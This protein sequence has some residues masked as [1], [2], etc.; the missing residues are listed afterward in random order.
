VVGTT[1]RKYWYATKAVDLLV[2][3]R[4]ATL[5]QGSITYDRWLPRM[6]YPGVGLYLENKV[7]KKTR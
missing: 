7:R 4:L 2:S 5:F 3:T 1:C 6:N